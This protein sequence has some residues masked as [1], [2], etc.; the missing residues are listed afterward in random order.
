MDVKYQVF[1][2]STYNDL[3]EERKE[4]IEALINLSHFP[5]G[6]ELFNAAD[7]TQWDVIKRRIGESDYY[8]LILSD[9]YGSTDKDGMGFTE[10]EYDYAI[11]L[12]KPVI[13]FVRSEEEI[14]KLPSDLRESEY[15]QELENF[16]KKI[17]GKLYKIWT[18]QHDLSKKFFSS[19]AELTSV[20]PQ[21]GW[22][23]GDTITEQHSE[24]AIK[25]AEI[26]DKYQK[27]KDEA[28]IAPKVFKDFE[29]TL[30]SLEELLNELISNTSVPVLQTDTLKIRVLG[31][32]FHKSFPFIKN[33]I[34]EHC[35][36]GKRI[37]IRLSK[38]D[39]TYSKINV[40]DDIWSN[41][42]DVYLKQQEE[43][44][45]NIT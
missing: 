45:K 19:F 28:L 39:R 41:Y 1:V 9:R 43:F 2:S 20:K 3:E 34:E 31:V 14:N 26:N 36:S 12:N 17:S 29:H 5:V 30:P 13:S 16:R 6:M 35:K 27:L 44:I 38:L 42:Y 22:V 25:Y 33:F 7:D 4:I 11:K 15:R 21:I 37:E 23:R 18:N 24:L 8:V 32:C 40:L 10:K